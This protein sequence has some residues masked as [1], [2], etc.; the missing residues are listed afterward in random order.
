MVHKGME[1][2]AGARVDLD[3]GGTH[4]WLVNRFLVPLDQVGSNLDRRV[5]TR[6]PQ[7]GLAV[8]EITRFLDRS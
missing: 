4:G 3:I 6:S 8:N 5:T 1:D 2:G 7:R